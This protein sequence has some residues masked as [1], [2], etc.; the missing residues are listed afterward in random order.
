MSLQGPYVFC[1]FCVCVWREM[2]YSVP[3]HV[4]RNLMSP[5]I[6]ICDIICMCIISAL[7][8]IMVPFFVF[9]PPPPPK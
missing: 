2:F 1:F 9:A 4:K 5:R 8:D 7:F 6:H 3:Q